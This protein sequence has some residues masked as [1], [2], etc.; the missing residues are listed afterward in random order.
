MKAALN[1]VASTGFCQDSVLHRPAVSES[2]GKQGLVHPIDFGP[3]GNASP[4]TLKLNKD[5][6][7]RVPLLSLDVGP[8]AVFGLVAQSA[9]NSVY[10]AT[11]W[12]HAHI[13]QKI[14]ERQPFV[15]DSNADSAVAT[16]LVVPRVCTS[17]NHIDPS[18]VCRRLLPAHNV[19]VTFGLFHGLVGALS[20]AVLAAS[21]VYDALCR[22]KS[23]A[24]VFASYLDFHAPIIQQ[25]KQAGIELR[26]LTIRRQ[27]EYR[28]CMGGV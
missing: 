4:F 9:V 14:L 3:L 11:R 24:A 16:V 5:V 22:R 21:R 13:R 6:G 1:S 28:Q 17:A 2:P 26:G 20:G 15:A 19:T 27:E 18:D 23:S 7:L 25:D 8:P 10:R 12:A